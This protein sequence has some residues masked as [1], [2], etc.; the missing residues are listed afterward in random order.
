MR[1][2]QPAP[3]LARA[4]ALVRPADPD[5][6][7]GTR[8]A[9]LAARLAVARGWTQALAEQLRHAAGLHDIGKHALPRSLLLERGPL[10]A[11][12]RDHV[13]LHTHAATWLL[14]GLHHPVFQLAH[15][16]GR[17]HHE[18]WDGSGY[19]DRLKATEIP[20][21]ARVVAACDVWDALT[22]PRPYRAAL[23]APEAAETIGAMA[24][25]ALDPDITESLLQL[26]R[27]CETGPAP[28]G[29]P[30]ASPCC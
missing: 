12:Q 15:A 14:A 30:A 10:T 19:P 28:S 11:R 3:W 1:T 25:T 20:L 13:V 9:Q 24:G 29:T 22:H 26:T 6:D 2:E 4:A 8:V 18:R 7:H 27:P 16:V 17:A 5:P 23:P 21:P